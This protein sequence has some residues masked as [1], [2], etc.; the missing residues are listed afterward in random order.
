MS[1][2]RYQNG[3]LRRK[4]RARF[5]AM[6]LPCAICGKP[7][8]YDEPSDSKHPFSFVIDEIMPVS[9]WQQAGYSSARAAAEDFNNLQP[10]HYICNQMKSDKVG[11]RLDMVRVVQKAVPDIKHIPLDGKW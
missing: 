9:K 8:R 6:G 1:N 3:A 5:K 10:A 4:N 2:P 11:F 7:I